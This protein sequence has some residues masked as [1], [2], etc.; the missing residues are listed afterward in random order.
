MRRLTTV[1]YGHQNLR[2]LFTVETGE[3]LKG[4][5]TCVVR[6]ARGTELGVVLAKPIEDSQGEAGCGESACGSCAT[7][8]G[9]VLRRATP[10]ELQ[11]ALAQKKRGVMEEIRYAREKSK[12]QRLGMKIVGAE[13]LFEKEKLIVHFSSN[14]RAEFHQFVRELGTRFKTRIEL[15]PIGARDEARLVGDVASCGRELCCKSFLHDLQPVSMRTAKQQMK[16]LDPTKIAGQCGKLK[17]CLRYEDSVYIELQKTLPKRGAYVRIEHG[18]ARVRNCDLLLQKLVVEM[19]NGD[20][21]VV[22]VSQLLETGVK[23]P[24]PTAAVE[25]GGAVAPPI[26]RVGPARVEPASPTSPT[27][28]A[29]QGGPPPIPPAAPGDD[30]DAAGPSDLEG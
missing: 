12:E 4:G 8:Q 18:L 24:R 1:R 14:G 30:D 6:S 5:D 23:P 15:K 29:A 13:Y 19:E 2:G 21:H 16:T 7:S 9:T 27:S 3:E 28:P 10:D 25:P 20:R 17:C 22:H 11:N 26:R